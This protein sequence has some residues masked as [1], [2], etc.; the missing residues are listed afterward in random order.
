[1]WFYHGVM[2]PKDVD[3]MAN[4]VHPDEEQSDLHLHCFPELS[5]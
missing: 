5:V 4:S 3:C 1:M 2:H